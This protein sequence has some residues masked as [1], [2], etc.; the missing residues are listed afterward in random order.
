MTRRLLLVL[1]P[2]VALLL[3]A[4]GHAARALEK[5]TLT[6]ETERGAKFRFTV[7][8][9][10]TPEEQSQGLMFRQK[11]A[12][13]AG[14][15]FIY[16]TPQPA[17]FWMKNTYLP[18]DMLFIEPDGRIERVHA[19]AEPLS[20]APIEGPMRTKAVLEINGGTAAKLGIHP[21]DRVIHESIAP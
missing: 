21:G 3:L 6:I 19:N 1:A 11:L 17:G 5:S 9:A 8:L 15:L 2:L 20:T 16:K 14:M 12:P 4:P 18:L 13:D 10:R 7:E